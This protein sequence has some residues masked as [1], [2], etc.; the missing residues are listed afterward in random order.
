MVS[1]FN[2]IEEN[3]KAIL[4]LAKKLRIRIEQRFTPIPNFLNKQ[5]KQIEVFE[6]FSVT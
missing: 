5:L 3:R 1:V 2:L 4:E 6:S